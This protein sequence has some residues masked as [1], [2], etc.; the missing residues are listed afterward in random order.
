MMVDRTRESFL[1]FWEELYRDYEHT[2]KA[3][4]KTCWCCSW[5][6][7]M[8]LGYKRALAKFRSER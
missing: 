2:D 8:K 3:R 7:G 1:E 4:E 6:G 5:A